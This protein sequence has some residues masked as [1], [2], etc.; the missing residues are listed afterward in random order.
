MLLT[1]SGKQPLLVENYK[2]IG[3]W[4]GANSSG[5]DQSRWYELVLYANDDDRYAVS[6]VYN[7]RWDGE[8]DY[9]WATMGTATD[10]ADWLTGL[11][12]PPVPPIWGY[13]PTQAYESRQ[14][15]IVESLRSQ[16]H[17]ALP[18]ILNSDK[19]AV[20]QDTEYPD[21]RA[22]TFDYL[23]TVGRREV[24]DADFTN[25]ELCLVA[26]SLN[27]TMFFDAEWMWWP[28]NVEDSIRLNRYDEK[29]SVDRDVLM[30]KIHA[31]SVVGKF[32]MAEAV[33]RFWRET[34]YSQDKDTAQAFTQLGILT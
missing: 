31:L 14:A 18:Y 21:D 20:T 8:A 22:E 2:E 19:F 12:D 27:G 11:N 29:W 16:W 25:N 23:M 5:R 10:V 34:S 9:Y 30:S 1:R 28:A 33:R 32:A 26:D 6:V 15:R 24:C 7:T 4:S 17:A 13:P 3:R